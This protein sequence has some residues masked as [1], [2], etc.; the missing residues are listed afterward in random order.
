MTL[1]VLVTVF[2]HFYRDD[3]I[4]TPLRK[5]FSRYAPLWAL[6][7][8]YVAIRGIVLGGMAGVISRPGLSV[9]EIGLSAVSLTGQYLWKLLWPAHLS[10][11][12]VFHKSSHLTDPSVLFG[13]LGLACYAAAF[14]ILWR[15]AH[16]LSFAILWL[17][18]T[19]GPV[20]NARWMPASV[21]AERYLYLPSVGFCWLVGWAAV[22]LWT[23]GGAPGA[24]RLLRP[25]ARAVPALLVIVALLYGMKTVTRNRDW[26]A[27]E[28][29][30]RQALQTQAN[31]SLILSNIGAIFYNRGDAAGAEH[32]WLESLDAG[33]T[34]VFALDNMAILRQHEQRYVEAI[35][36]S[37]RALRARPAYTVAHVDLAETLAL[38]GRTAEAE[39]QF[40]IATALS[41]LSTRAHND[42]GKFLLDAGRVDDARSRVRTLHRCGF[43]D[44]R[45]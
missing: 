33:P 4:T 23:A 1:P 15:R 40:R 26:R 6:A 28:I 17:F 10:A 9:Y 20:L 44:G 7:A 12:Y 35:D 43:N 31:A 8:L 21:F 32:E 18:F 5:K 2:E 22:K 38:M 29:L 27:D 41:P 39:W 42:Y 37:R 16:I 11:F 25:V 19:L 3:R 30:F 45:L 13:L 14:V 34:N 36:Y 24:S